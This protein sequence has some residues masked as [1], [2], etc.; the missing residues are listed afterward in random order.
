MNWFKIYYFRKFIK[1]VIKFLSFD[2][3][4]LFSADLDR[5]SENI[6]GKIRP[7]V[8]GTEFQIFD[9]EMNKNRDFIEV[10]DK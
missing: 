3:L 9:D 1:R 10:Q 7:N 6:V 5:Y 8:V 2:L 4:L